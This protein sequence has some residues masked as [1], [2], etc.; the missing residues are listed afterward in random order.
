MAAS[1]SQPKAPPADRRIIER[2]RLIKL[3]DETDA[4]TILLLA[5][6]G[7]GKTTLARQWAKTLNGAIWV[8]LSQAH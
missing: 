2:P 3:L 7:Y 4:H 5:P 1:A 6:A 8:T